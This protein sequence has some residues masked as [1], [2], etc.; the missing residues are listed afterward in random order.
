MDT[1][2]LKAAGGLGPIAILTVYLHYMHI[3]IQLEYF[4]FRY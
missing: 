2:I 4:F 3:R 1:A